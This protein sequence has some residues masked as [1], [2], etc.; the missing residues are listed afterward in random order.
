MSQSSQSSRYLVVSGNGE[1]QKWHDDYG[2]ALADVRRRMGLVTL[3]PWKGRTRRHAAASERMFVYDG[4][5]WYTGYAEE[6]DPIEPDG[7]RVT[8]YCL[9]QQPPRTTAK[10]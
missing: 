3:H 6:Y 5:P 10:R 8:V 9:Q 1:S 4:V 2:S 7:P